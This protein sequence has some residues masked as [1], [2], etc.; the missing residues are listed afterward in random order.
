MITRCR[1]S[2]DAINHNADVIPAGVVD[3]RLSR[4][5]ILCHTILPIG[6]NAKDAR[7]QTE[8]IDHPCND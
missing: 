4:L 3:N 6:F 8:A 5:P 2:L 7:I 1:A